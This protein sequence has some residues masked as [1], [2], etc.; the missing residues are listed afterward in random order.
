MRSSLRPS[1]RSAKAGDPLPASVTASNTGSIPGDEVVQLYL[2][3][4]DVPGAPLKAL[5][6]FKRVHLE[7]GATQTVEFNLTP[8]DL[9]MVTEAGDPTI[10]A[11]TYQAK[12]TITGADGTIAFDYCRIS[13][14][15]PPF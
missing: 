8:R 5:R 4:P 10:P 15:S 2:S 7:P 13:L 9:S 1:D 3:F 14:K 11:G 12:V 6:A